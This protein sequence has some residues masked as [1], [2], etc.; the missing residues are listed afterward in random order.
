MAR[1]DLSPSDFDVAG[2]RIGIVAARFNDDVVSR[3]LEAALDTLARHGLDRDGVPVARVPG[4]F[5]LPLA[6]RWLATCYGSL[7]DAGE[8]GRSREE[9]RIVHGAAA[10]GDEHIGE[11]NMAA[12]RSPAP[13]AS[14]DRGRDDPSA[15]ARGLEG[16]TILDDERTG[17][18][19]VAA[20]GRRGTTLPEDEPA[21]GG[22]VAA[23]ERRET[24]L[25]DD[26][27]AGGDSGPREKPRTARNVMISGNVTADAV[28]ALGAVIR[29]E[30]PHFDY[31][32]AE[33][34][35]GIRAVSLELDVPVVFGVLTCD[36]HAQALE[37]AGGG[38]HRSRR[39]RAASPPI[40]PNSIH[41]TPTSPIPPAA[42]GRPPGTGIA[43]RGAKRPSRRWRWSPCGAASALDPAAARA[44][45]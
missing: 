4:A 7:T 9:R 14:A 3:L 10:S 45:L 29:G 43:T 13:A 22:D 28:I 37:R 18:D 17:E 36:D 38:P 27:R 6:A 12:A 31:V 40:S 11:D 24:M 19:D 39:R 26:E 30:T 44:C 2:A 5:E 21:G 23:P 33:A 20:R 8:G 42:P 41:P 32:C 25:P 15:A 16:A 35:R 34:A 1:Y